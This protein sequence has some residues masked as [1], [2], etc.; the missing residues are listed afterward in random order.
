MS[1]AIKGLD[2]ERA[3]WATETNPMRMLDFLL[4]RASERKSRLFACA[5]IRDAWPLL[6]DHSSREFVEAVE[7]YA[8]GSKT[9][10]ELAASWKAV[11]PSNVS[12][13]LYGALRTLAVL[14]HKLHPYVN[15]LHWNASMAMDVAKVVIELAGDEERERVRQSDFLR[16][17]FQYQVGFVFSFSPP[18]S[19]SVLSW[20]HGAI[21]QL[22]QGIYD[23]G[24]FDRLPMLAK[25]LEEAECDNDELIGHCRSEEPHIRGCWALDVV[26]GKA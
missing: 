6:T 13:E 15:P 12:Q 8:D 17:Q 4:F 9:E 5:C 1:R 18:A 23:E 20:K 21:P 2:R 25:A 19:S 14:T 10:E 3:A 22:A 26:L 24:A 7:R 11:D 16:C